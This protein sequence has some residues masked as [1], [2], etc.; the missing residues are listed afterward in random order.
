MKKNK[1]N[2]P[3]VATNSDNSIYNR[4][5]EDKYF[6]NTKSNVK[7]KNS[8]NWKH[9]KRLDYYHLPLDDNDDFEEDPYTVAQ[10]FIDRTQF[11]L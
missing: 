1:Y 2:F 4:Y 11:P 8:E 3:K 9:N 6:E 10:N 7:N 5:V